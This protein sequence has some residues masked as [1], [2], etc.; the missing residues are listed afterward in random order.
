MKATLLYR[1]ASVLL[2]VFALGHTVGFLKFKP[3]SPEGLA[4]LEAMNNT[5]FQSRGATHTYGEI[6]TGFGL[7]A[8]LFLLFAACLA[9]HL[10]NLAR[11]SPQ[12][13]GALGW[14]FCIAQVLGMVLSWIYFSPPPVVFSAVI[15]LCL[16]W[17]TW[18]TRAKAQS[19][20][21]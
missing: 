15:A 10:G 4:V 8:T 16:G 17:A 3:S 13:I 11:T 9:W 1:I 7:Y 21:A 5:H 6:Y 12:A 20:H 2:I 19:A 18:L 14:V